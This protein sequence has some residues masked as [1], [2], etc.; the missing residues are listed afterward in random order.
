MEVLK[1]YLVRNFES[2]FVLL[3][4]ISVAF[5]NY[6][7]PYKLAFLN[8]YY[9]P[10]LLAAYYLDLRRVLLGA[11]FCIL[12]VALYAYLEPDSFV[13]GSSWLDLA[14]NVVTWGCFLILTGAV[15][16]NLNR[17]LHVEVEHT[18]ALNKDLL[19]SQER[20]EKADAE[21]REHAGELERKVEERTET[22]ERSKV[23]IEDLKKRVEEALYST[24]DPSVVKLMIEKRLR[25]EKRQ[26][27]VLFADLVQ[28][29]RYSEE[30][31]AEMVITD[32]NR[33]LQEMEGTLLDYR[34]HID[35]YIG[36]GIMVEF[37]APID[38]ER[39]ALLAV[40]AGLKMQERLAKGSFPWQ[41]RVGVTTGKPIVGLI[42][43]RRQTYTAIGDTVNLAARI[44]G[45][46]APGSVTVDAE[47]YEAVKIF[48]DTRKKTVLPFS[49]F[50]D[51]KVIESINELLSRI[52]G[53]PKDLESVRKV[54]FLFLE[55]NNPLQAQEYLKKAMELEPNDD[56][57]KLA[58]AEVSMKLGQMEEIAIR[59]KKS[60]LH[61]YEVQGLRDPLQNREKI[62]HKTFERFGE[63]VSKAAEYPAD[64][65]LPV[66]GLDGCVG[67]SRAVGFLAFAL[68]DALG[69]SDQEKREILAAGY[70][71]DIGKAIV[72]HHLLN[73]S[74]S[75]SREEFSE[76]T[77]HSQE[78]VRILR[79]KG[80]QNESLFTII[81]AHHEAMNG[82]GYP[83]G[84]SG[85]AIPLGARILAVADAYDALTSWRP[86]R[87]RWDY[88]AAISEMARETKE[89]KFD[90]KVMD[91]LTKLLE[92]RA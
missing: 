83:A 34:A 60:R 29:T 92:L 42:G 65:I 67:H 27:S 59:G 40:L 74:G 84:L 91:A 54:G 17:K 68:A 55:A 63:L 81:A 9:I 12:M 1:N 64:L 61:L 78:S 57:V 46:A 14:M 90:P 36:D 16:G 39:H 69:L 77:K 20:L 8:F 43:H 70:L 3:I 82:S 25:T 30:R 35:K 88:R 76:V 51:P 44:E 48:V 28:F 50:D 58:F 5:I 80:Y 7:I 89:G 15:V 26:I 49:G 38:Y 47:T 41:M 33:Y 37:G 53:N 31:R 72:P 18:R 6:F 79:S 71:M 2:A 73:R 4:L 32:L 24:M 52:D 56:R 22:L 19:E 21:L 23:A 11:F 62:P 45:I 86:Y 13:P 87:D 10:I 66:E 85:E 75:L